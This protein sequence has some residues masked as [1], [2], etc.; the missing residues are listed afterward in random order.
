MEGNPLRNLKLSLEKAQKS[1][2]VM[3]TKINRFDE[4]L[5]AIDEQMQPIQVTT[6]IYTKAKEN[7][8]LTLTEVEKTYEY[9]RVAQSVNSTICGGLMLQN[10]AKQKEFVDAFARLTEAKRFFEVHREDIKSSGS[11]LDQIEALI[12]VIVRTNFVSSLLT[13]TFLN[14]R[15]LAV[16]LMNSVSFFCLVERR[17]FS[18]VV[19]T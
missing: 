2:S 10:A 17:L 4:R 9:F 3:L 8:G 19:N 12:K 6:A 14:R 16:A 1:T 15:Q 18:T 11:A 5:A 13:L 7:I